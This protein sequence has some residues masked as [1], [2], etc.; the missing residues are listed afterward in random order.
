MPGHRFMSTPAGLRA[1]VT[2]VTALAT[3][4]QQPMQANTTGIAAFMVQC[5]PLLQDMQKTFWGN[6]YAFMQ[7]VA[8]ACA[9][10]FWA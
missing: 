3:H 1:V 7:E 6:D 2:L 10:T 8:A 5:S 9:D 4:T